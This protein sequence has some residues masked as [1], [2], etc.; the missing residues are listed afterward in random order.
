MAVKGSK[1]PPAQAGP[2]ELR[3]G[4]KIEEIISM[5]I[6]GRAAIGPQICAD[7]AMRLT[8]GVPAP[9]GGKPTAPAAA[10]PKPPGHGGPATPSIMSTMTNGPK[11][12][13][14]A[15]TTETS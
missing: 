6:K 14:E 9:A 3:E 2:L 13:T 8:P 11:A 1:S 10:A 4:G 7:L 12:P 15:I 5:A